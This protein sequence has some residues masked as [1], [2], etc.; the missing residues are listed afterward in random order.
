MTAAEKANLR[1]HFQGW[2][3]SQFLH[4]E[5]GALLCAS[6]IIA[7]APSL[8]GKLFAAGQAADEARHVEVFSRLLR[9]K[10]ELSY[11]V[12]APLRALLI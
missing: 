6:K 5:Q 1:R 8:E 2:Q 7:E 10:I 3:L 12:S 11:P 9:D 4:G